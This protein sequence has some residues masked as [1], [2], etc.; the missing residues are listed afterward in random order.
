L[1]ATCWIIC[2]SCNEKKIWCHSQR[3]RC[4]HDDEVIAVTNNNEG[5]DTTSN[6][7]SKK[8]VVVLLGYMGTAY[9]GFQIN[10]DQ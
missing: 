10:E 4:D 3:I 6:D 1:T 5:G 8:K 9:G 2:Q 7:T